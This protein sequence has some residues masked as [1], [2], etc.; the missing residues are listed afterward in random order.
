MPSRRR[1]DYT[2]DFNSLFIPA[3]KIL[4]LRNELLYVVQVLVVS[5]DLAI[6]FTVDETELKKYVL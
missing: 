1:Q 5:K 2:R 6:V 4:F 3:M